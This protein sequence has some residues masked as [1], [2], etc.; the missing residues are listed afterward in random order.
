MN[1][2]FQRA[3]LQGTL[4]ALCGFPVDTH[5]DGVLP[6]I[7]GGAGREIAFSNS[8]FPTKAYYL[9]ARA[10]DYSMRV[11]VNSAV[12]VDGTA[13]IAEAEVAFY[14]SAHEGDEAYAVDSEELRAFFYPKVRE[15]MRGIDNNGE[16]FPFPGT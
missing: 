1:E 4:G 15:F 3:K 5:V 6:K 16:I 13:D 11:T 12:E 14:P 2:D 9:A 8:L 10:A 7:F